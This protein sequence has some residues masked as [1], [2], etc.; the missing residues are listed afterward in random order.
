MAASALIMLFIE[1]F[2]EM[3][4]KKFLKIYRL[5]KKLCSEIMNLLQDSGIFFSRSG[6]FLIS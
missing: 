1:K 4:F 2:A 3:V 6:I 5:E